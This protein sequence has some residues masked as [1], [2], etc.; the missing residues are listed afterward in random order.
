[1]FHKQTKKDKDGY[2]SLL[3]NI[4]CLLFDLEFRSAFL[5]RKMCGGLE[6]KTINPDI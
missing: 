4:N 3:T 5:N 2:E 1:M 6:L